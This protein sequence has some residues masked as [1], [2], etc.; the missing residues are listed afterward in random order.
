LNIYKNYQG[1][2]YKL[3]FKREKGNVNFSARGE[4]RNMDTHTPPVEKTVTDWLCQ[5]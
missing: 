5:V 3:T 4:Y 1:S 2:V